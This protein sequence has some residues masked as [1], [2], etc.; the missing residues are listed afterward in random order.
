MYVH[1]TEYTLLSSL[2]MD[3]IMAFYTNTP[4]MADARTGDRLDK[5]HHAMRMAR[6]V[7]T[8]FYGEVDRENRALVK[9]RLRWYS[10]PYTGSMPY[11]IG[12][13]PHLTGTMP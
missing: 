11:I 1:N 3:E 2:A 10:L 12:N 8:Y 6:M 4:P 9:F 13:M 7:L 5:L